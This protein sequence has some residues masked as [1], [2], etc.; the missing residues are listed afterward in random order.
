VNNTGINKLKA[1]CR[2]VRRMA[3]NG[4]GQSDIAATLGIS[5]REVAVI[6]L[7]L[8]LTSL[9]P[10]LPIP[11][12]KHRDPW[13][14]PGDWRYRNDVGPD[15]APLV[16]A[17]PIAAAELVHQAGAA[18]RPGAPPA[19][20]ETH[21]SEATESWEHW[22]V[23]GEK[24]GRSKL[25]EDDVREIRRKHAAGYGLLELAWDYEVHHRTIHAIVRGETWSHVK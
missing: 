3:A 14:Q 11:K 4:W 9:T 12:P 20:T 8:P 15:G 17:S 2:I 10:P 16:I 24:H 13:R 1:L 6:L 25:S 5:K 19:G 22:S 23:R 7:R 21:Q 18:D